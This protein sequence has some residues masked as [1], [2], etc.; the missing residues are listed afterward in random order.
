MLTLSR[1]LSISISSTTVFKFSLKLESVMKIII[2]ITFWN[3]SH[4]SWYFRKFS[5]KLS[6][7]STSKT[8]TDKRT[9]EEHQFLKSV[10]GMPFRKR[11]RCQLRKI[12]VTVLRI[13]LNLRVHLEITRRTIK[14]TNHRIIREILMARVQRV[15]QEN[16]VVVQKMWVLGKLFQRKLLQGRDFLWQSIAWEV[17]ILLK[18]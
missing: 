10:S 14:L 17:K 2:T 6:W 8:Y 5:M 12:L 11:L 3:N 9:Q 16:L 1:H 7:L 15:N 4:N 13:P 18:V